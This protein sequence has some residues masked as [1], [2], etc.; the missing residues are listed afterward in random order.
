MRMVGLIVLLLS[1][2]FDRISKWIVIDLINLSDHPIVV[3]PIFDLVIVKNTGVSFGLFQNDLNVV[4]WILIFFAILVI[5]FLIIWLY[6][7]N[8]FILSI[9]LGM[10]IGGAAGNVTDRIV[11]GHVID[12]L[13]FHIGKWSFPVFNIADTA[14]VCGFLLII[15][16][17]FIIR[18]KKDR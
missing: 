13:H 11:W 5:I 8:S 14:I 18:R 1:Y 2:V 3:L 6:R 7:S 4:R 12:F 17:G 10:I 16:D 15:V 9:A